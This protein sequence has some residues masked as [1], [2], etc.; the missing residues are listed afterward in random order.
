MYT[1]ASFSETGNSTTVASFA[2]PPLKVLVGWLPSGKRN[3]GS[4]GPASGAGAGPNVGCGVT[5]TVAS[6][7][8]KMP[9]IEIAQ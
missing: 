3:D 2:A 9:P 4:S 5:P 8:S 1:P 6:A 7:L